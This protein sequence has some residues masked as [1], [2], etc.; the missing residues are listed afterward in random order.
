MDA[1]E[2]GLSQIWMQGGALESLRGTHNP[3]LKPWF[4]HLLIYLNPMILS[5]HNCK[6][7]INNIYFIGLLEEERI[8][9]MCLAQSLI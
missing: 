7:K 8:H 5:F 4:H 6:I 2:Q 9:V 3:G 1:F